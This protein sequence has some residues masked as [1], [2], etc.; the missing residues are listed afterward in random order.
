MFAFIAPVLIFA[1]FI[2]LLLVS[3]SVPII[4]TIYLFRLSANVGASVFDTSAS[5]TARF[6]V[7]GYCLSAV[8]VSL[9]VLT[10]IYLYVLFLTP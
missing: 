7:W 5:G 8:N 10:S 1:A 6:G 9:V 4:K 2:L 3:L